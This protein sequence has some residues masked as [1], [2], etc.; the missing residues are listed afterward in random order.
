[1]TAHP[2]AGRAAR[3]RAGAGAD[4]HLVPVHD[5][6][7]ARRPLHDVAGRCA[8]YELVI[9][10]AESGAD[11]DGP[12]GGGGERDTSQLLSAVFA[13]F[14]IESVSDGRP[15]FIAFTRAFLTGVLPVPVEPD[16]VVV[17]VTERVVAD[18]EL[19]LG[20][21][22]LRQAGYR[23]AVDDYRGDL[24]RS[25]LVELADYVKIRIDSLPPLVVPGLVQSCRLT[26]ATLVATGIEDAGSLRRCADLGFELFQGPYL[27]RSAVLQRRVLSPSQLICVRLLGD[28]SDPDTPVERIEHL[29]GGDP[30]LSLRMLRSAHSASGAGREVESLRQAL[31]LIGPR[32]LRSWLVLT[33]L[34]GTASPTASDDL[35]TVLAR[36]RAC[37]RLAPEHA[38][39]AYTVGLL[40]GAAQLL[41]TDVASVADVA[42]IGEHARLALVDH[43]GPVGQVLAA[44]RAQ[45]QDDAATLALGELDAAT[46]SREYLA[47]LAEALD[48]VHELAH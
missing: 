46:V 17:E 19:L 3:G 8:A 5:V 18:R 24:G 45:E 2:T 35:W 21:E 39:L 23:I 13:T 33:L 42:G 22:Q 40:D 26:G 31:V 16:A 32:R 6:R 9:R 44:V 20:L 14:G 10:H 11:D 34:E 1:M 27:G 43:S 12:A 37:Q 4:R 25:S 28:L 7:M 30:G 48:L 15:V 36:A 47:A 29:V 38:D 41:G